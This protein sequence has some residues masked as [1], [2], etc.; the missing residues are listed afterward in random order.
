MITWEFTSTLLNK[1]INIIF[2][3][4]VN[5]WCPFMDLKPMVEEFWVCSLMCFGVF[6]VFSLRKY[7][8]IIYIYMCVKTI[9]NSFVIRYVYV[10]V[11]G[12]KQ[13][14]SNKSF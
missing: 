2:N 10:F 13:N 8:D 4:C 3:T 5:T 9:L 1:N 11:N 14:I 6:F 12:R 7:I